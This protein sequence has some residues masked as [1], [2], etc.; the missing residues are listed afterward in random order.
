MKE[1][2]SS[3]VLAG[4]EFSNNLELKSHR[5]KNVVRKCVSEYM[6]EDMVSTNWITNVL[7]VTDTAKITIN[8]KKIE[9]FVQSFQVI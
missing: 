6:N 9:G 4:E 7:D 1:I 3:H 5:F 8:G 2:I